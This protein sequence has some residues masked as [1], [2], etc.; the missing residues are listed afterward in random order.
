MLSSGKCEACQVD[1]V[2]GDE[3][4]IKVLRWIVENFTNQPMPVGIVWFLLGIIIVIIIVEAS[5]KCTS[6]SW[7]KSATCSLSYHCSPS[8][9][10]ASTQLAS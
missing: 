10:A 7:S 6:C 5:G 3:S 2:L 1:L 4:L 9:A 8:L